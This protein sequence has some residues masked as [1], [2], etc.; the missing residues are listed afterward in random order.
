MDCHSSPMPNGT[1]KV[2]IRIRAKCRKRR[3]PKGMRPWVEAPLR[4]GSFSLK[5][6][7]PRTAR[8]AVPPRDGS[9]AGMRWFPA[10]A[11][12]V[13]SLCLLSGIPLGS[14]DD[15]RSEGVPPSDGAKR[16]WFTRLLSHRESTCSLHVRAPAG[17]GGGSHLARCPEMVHQYAPL[18]GNGVRHLAQAVARLAVE[19]AKVAP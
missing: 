18:R 17:W 13:G 9:P 16:R 15:P 3:P 8:R 1:S 14:G 2:A 5:T 11:V 4:V 19:K 6:S 12:R 7:R 10:P